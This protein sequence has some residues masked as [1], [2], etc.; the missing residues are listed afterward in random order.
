[1]RSFREFVMTLSAL[2]CDRPHVG[3]VIGRLMRGGAP[4]RPLST[5]AMTEMRLSLGRLGQ[6]TLIRCTVLGGPS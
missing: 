1:M 3:L 5:S 2:R 4:S 6:G